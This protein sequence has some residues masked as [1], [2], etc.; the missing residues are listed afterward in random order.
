MP[1]VGFKCDIRRQGGSLVISMPKPLIEAFEI[2]EGDTVVL[3]AS[4]DGI[5]LRKE[6]DNGE[7]E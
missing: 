7:E 5:L 1:K 6:G 3:V 2:K 4:D